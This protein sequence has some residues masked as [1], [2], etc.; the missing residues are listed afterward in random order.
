MTVFSGECDGCGNLT[1][2]YC[3]GSLVLR[4]IV[5]VVRGLFIEDRIIF[6]PVCAKEGKK[7]IK[8]HNRKMRGIDVK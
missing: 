5:K 4:K 1:T 2:T 3:N 8:A 6:C 7:M